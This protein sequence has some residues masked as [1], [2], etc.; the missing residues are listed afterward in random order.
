MCF[1][2]NRKLR[3]LLYKNVPRGSH[4]G[5]EENA[6]FATR[7]R[8]RILLRRILSYSAFRYVLCCFGLSRP[9]G[10]LSDFPGGL[11]SPKQSMQ[12]CV[13]KTV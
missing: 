12:R 10:K 6:A 13:R 2:Y 3:P 1:L 7:R 4:C 9:P 11:D 8:R 5:G